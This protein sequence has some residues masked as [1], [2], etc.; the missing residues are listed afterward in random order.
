MAELKALV[1]V[2][3]V[4]VPTLAYS[5][6]VIPR[7]SPKIPRLLAISPVLYLLFIL[8]WQFSTVHLR[9]I[10]AFFLTWLCCFKL[11]L[12]CYDIGPLSRPWSTSSFINFVAVTAFP[13]KVKEGDVRET[14]NKKKNDESSRKK[15]QPPHCG[16]RGGY[17]FKTVLNLAIKTSLLILIIFLYNY[18]HFYTSTTLLILYC[19]HIFLAL[20]VVLGSWAVMAKLIVGSQLEPQFNKPYLSSSLKEFWGQRWNLIVTNMLRPTVYEPVLN[21]WGV[22]ARAGRPPLGARVAALMATF[23]VSGLMHELMFYYMT[24]GQRPSWEVTLFFILHGLL[25][26]IEVAI[27]RRIGESAYPRFPKV[28]RVPLTL[29]IVISTGS[30][31]FFPPLTR[32]GADV[33]GIKEF[34]QVV[35][36]SREWVGNMSFVGAWSKCFGD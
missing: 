23:V 9:S 13:I 10:S 8:P 21:L 11:V 19:F 14:Q 6:T 32:S 18:K 29:G 4:L 17:I 31:L 25:T 33:K 35:E 34:D 26:G 30:W 36:W 12:L 27:G 20:E 1:R 3:T 28:V 16:G 24:G 7:L 15:T 2:S 22:S 5:Y